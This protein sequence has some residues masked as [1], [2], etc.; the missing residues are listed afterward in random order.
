MSGWLHILDPKVQVKKQH[1]PFSQLFKKPPGGLISP[2]FDEFFWM[3][4]KAYFHCRVFN[5]YFVTAI[6][7]RVGSFT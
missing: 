2:I 1:V 3:D 5:E 7:L 4:D 6:L